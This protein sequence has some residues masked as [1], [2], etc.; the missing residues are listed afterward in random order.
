[1]LMDRGIQKLRK[2]K[3]WWQDTAFVEGWGLYAEELGKDMGFYQDP[4]ADLG[5]LTG[6][7]WRACRLVVDS[8][9][10][11]K[12]WS[13]DEAIRYLQ[14]KSAAPDGTIVR[15]V[16]RYIALP[17]QATA[18]TLGMLKVVSERERA[19]QALGS[20][21]DLREYHHIGFEESHSPPGALE[22]RVG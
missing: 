9:L 11:Y 3:E 22:E 12:R 19:R 2:V 21:F 4:Y 13:R 1:M 18:F 17:G 7:L 8:G 16:D 15:E 20:Q 5:R 10:H 6:E 14:E